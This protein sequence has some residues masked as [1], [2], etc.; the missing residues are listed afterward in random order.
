MYP[1]NGLDLLEWDAD[2]EAYKT[3]TQLLTKVLLEENTAL[4]N[5]YL[6]SQR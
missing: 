2:D 3:Y 6:S 5:C 1:G 4:F